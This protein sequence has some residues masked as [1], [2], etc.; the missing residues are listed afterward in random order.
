MLW[1]A[2]QAIVAIENLADVSY[3]PVIPVTELC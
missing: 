3:D 1:L 2:A